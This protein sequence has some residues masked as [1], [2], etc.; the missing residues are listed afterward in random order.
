MFIF[1]LGGYRVISGT[2]QE[3]I[4]SRAESRVCKLQRLTLFLLSVL[5][6]IDIF[7]SFIV[8]PMGYIDFNADIYII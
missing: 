7:V 2:Y 5:V 3:L 1:L 4:S 6:N 8:R